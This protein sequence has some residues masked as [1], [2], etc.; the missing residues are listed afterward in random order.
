MHVLARALMLMAAMLSAVV[1][2][3][4][5]SV[6]SQSKEA[7]AGGSIAG[8]ITI[9]GK[10]AAGIAVMLMSSYS[11]PRIERA[12]AKT[13]TDQDGHFQLMR[14]PA[15]NY[16]VLAFAPAYC[17]ETEP[18]YPTDEGK[19][20]MLAEGESVDGM[21]ITLRRGGVITGRVSDAQGRP[22]VQQM[23]TLARVD[24]NGRRQQPVYAMNFRM[25]Q[26]DDRGVYRVYGL[27]AGRYLVSLGVDTRTGGRIGGGNMYYARTFHPGV[28]DESKATV[29]E[30]TEGGEAT[31]VDILMGRVEKTYAAAGRIVDAETGRPIPNT[32]YSYGSLRPNGQ[33]FLMGAMGLHT[34]SRGEFHIEGITPGR[35]SLFVSQNEGSEM[36][37][38]D[39]PFEI[40]DADIA[41]IEVKA[42]RGASLNGTVTL[43]GVAEQDLPA[44]LST[45]RLGFHLP[46]KPYQP[47]AS[48]INPDGSFRLAGLPAGRVQIFAANER[49]PSGLSLLRVE[50]EGVDQTAGIEVAAGENLSGVRVLLAYSIGV[51]RGQVKFGDDALPAGAQVYVEARRIGGGNAPNAHGAEAD[52]R[53]HFIIENLPPGQYEVIIEAMVMPSP[54]KPPLRFKEARQ[55]V[56]VTNDAKTDVTLIL[57]RENKD[58]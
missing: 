57:E 20:V 5:Q 52:S 37:I 12:F 22:L 53:G 42:R 28:A 1:C 2:A 36:V 50:R 39:T 6:I 29:V 32:S 13:T 38:E 11:D 48:R 10:P 30:V 49:R 17:L 40:N 41:G 23:V 33:P 34:D 18:R 51:I 54:G 9:A 35:Y 58:N 43:E 8:R 55:T 16:R 31:G 56:S 46:T 4:S 3:M 44:L 27:P 14:L 21:E 19:S 24:P 7:N 26:T 47:N 45:I 25:M 15:G